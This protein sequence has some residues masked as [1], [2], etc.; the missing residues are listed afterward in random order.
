MVSRNPIAWIV[1]G[2]HLIRGAPKVTV[3]RNRDSLCQKG[4]YPLAFVFS[5]N[6]S[7]LQQPISTVKGLAHPALG[8][9]PHGAPRIVP[10]RAGSWARP[11]HRGDL[12][13]A[14]VHR[15]FQRKRILIQPI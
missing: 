1:F 6:D 15:L 2:F 11:P 8:Q 13:Q 3:T 10:A 12:L 7:L 4:C 14:L 9:G 5:V